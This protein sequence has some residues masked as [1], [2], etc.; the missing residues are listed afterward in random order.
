MVKLKVIHINN[1]KREKNSILNCRCVCVSFWLKYASSSSS[2]ITL[3]GWRI[4][5][6]VNRTAQK[7]YS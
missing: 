3:S 1:K 2:E 5:V 4:L 6:K 7:I